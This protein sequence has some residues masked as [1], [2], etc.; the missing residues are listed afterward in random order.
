MPFNL[1][2]QFVGLGMFV[3]EP[4][5]AAGPAVHILMPQTGYDR[6]PQH[7]PMLHYPDASGNTQMAPVDQTAFTITGAPHAPVPRLPN[8]IVDLSALTTNRV[9][10]SMLQGAPSARLYA[11]VTLHNVVSIT[12]Q[13]MA[14]WTFGGNGTHAMAS[15]V[16]LALSITDAT[17]ALANG[18]L[19]RYAGSLP[20]VSPTKG[21]LHLRIDHMIMNAVPMPEPPGP[22]SPDHFK[23]YYDMLGATGAPMPQ[24]V[25]GSVNCPNPPLVLRKRGWWSLGRRWMPGV[26]PYTCMVSGGST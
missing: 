9:Q 20:T 22:F 1:E 26:D 6:I 11:R 14:Q 21:A 13:C 17:V 12:P 10:A 15:D 18:A 7:F 16:H 8:G 2:V 4:N 3:L 24:Y 25:K 23:A 19:G 5:N